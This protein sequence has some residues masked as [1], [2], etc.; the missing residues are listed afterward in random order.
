MLPKVIG[1]RYKLLQRIGGGS[2]GQTYLAEDSQLP[3]NPECIVKQ[4]KPQITD[5]GTLQ[6]ARRLF[7]SEAQVLH[8]LGSRHPQIPTLYAYFEEDQEFYLVQELVRGEPLTEELPPGSHWTEAQVI[9][10][11]EDILSILDYVHQQ[12]VIHRDIKPSNIMRRNADQKLMLI[13]FGAVKQIQKAAG[14]SDSNLTVAISTY[15]YSPPEQLQGKPHFSSDLYAVGMTA[16]RALTGIQPH[17][18]ERD[19]AGES[20]WKPKACVS[21]GLTAILDRMV[22]S[23]LVDRY[24]SAAEV[25]AD[26]QRLKQVVND[27]T[28]LTNAGGVV[29]ATQVRPPATGGHISGEETRQQTMAGTAVGN[30]LAPTIAP[31]PSPG[32]AQLPTLVKS[33]PTTVSKGLSVKG[34]YVGAALAGLLVFLGLFELVVPTFRPAYYVRRGNQLLDD[35]RAE[36][37]RDMFARAIEIQPNYAA[38]WAGQAN[39]FAELG[40]HDRAL[41]DYQKALELDPNNPDLLTSKGTL[42]YQMGEPQKALD[43]HEQAIAIDPNYARAW[44]GKGIALIGLQRYDEAVEAFDQAKTLRPSAPSVWQSKAIALEYQ[45]KMAEAAQVYSEALATYDDILREQ[46][47]RAEIWVERG[48]VLSKLGRHEQALESYEKALEINPDH[49]QALLQK[50]NVLFSPLGRTEEA[51]TISDRAIEVQPES[52]LAWHNRGSILAGGRGDFEGAIAAYDQAIELRPSFVPALRDRGFALSQWS[53]ALQAEGNTS[54]ASSKANAALESFDQA[55]NIN[56]NDHQSYVG[57]AI[58]LSNQQR[59]DEALNAF[60]RAQEI[61]PQDPLIWVNR[62]LVLERMGR[63]N[64]AIDAYDQ[65]L[66]IQPGFP[67]AVRS[68]NQLQ[69]RL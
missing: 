31:S 36:D 16:I 38:G 37:A 44:H 14:G 39:A 18:L 46:P 41:V 49:F 69:Q 57:R 3:G 25:L 62:G 13:D 59:Y 40:R 68:K 28:M 52:H 29:A 6:T 4:L 45:G 47:R 67:P 51:V 34:W 50:G 21:D 26:V 24:Q 42:L 33:N 61:Q 10:F 48:S 11:L 53:Q 64:E 1:G 58:A 15:G 55:L 66:K 32:V 43:T 23:H 19:Q 65:A 20:I 8:S 54:M 60:D 2:F 9:D 7:N 17:Q 30:N 5:P 12:N 63:N 56:P 27:P 22:A 35:A